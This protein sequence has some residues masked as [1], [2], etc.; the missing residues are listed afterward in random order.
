M[1]RYET[2]MHL[3]PYLVDRSRNAVDA[4]AHRGSYC[5]FLARLCPKV[6]AFEPNP[7][8]RDYLRAVVRPNVVISDAAL[9]NQPGKAE[10]VVP[11]SPRGYR[12][13]AGTLETDLYREDH[14]RFPVRIARLDDEAIEN[15]GFI[16]MDIEGHELK[17]LEGAKKLLQ[18]DRPVLL[19]EVREELNGTP[20]ME[21]LGFIESL[22]YLAFA[23]KD[24]QLCSCESIDPE[25][26]HEKPA[27]PRSGE[28]I[29]NFIFFPGSPRPACD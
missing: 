4:G 24:G 21:A 5:Y 29:M 13:T 15:V 27:H 26:Y 1:R 18:R 20:I 10:F 28:R 19:L 6:Y 22:G 23:V 25:M 12:N 8:M 3:L 9:S 17:A 2:E 7:V 11:N 14:V 16:K